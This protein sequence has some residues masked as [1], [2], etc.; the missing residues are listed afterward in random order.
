MDVTYSPSCG[1]CC[2]LSSVS[3]AAVAGIVGAQ[4][5]LPWL[6]PV[7][8]LLV[9][10]LI[11][12]TGWSIFWDSTH[13]LTDGFDEELE[14]ELEDRNI[15]A[16][17]GVLTD[18]ADYKA[19]RQQYFREL[20]RLQGPLQGLAGESRLNCFTAVT[21]HHTDFCGLQGPSGIHHVLEQ[22]P[23]CKGLQ[24]LRQTR[25]HTLALDGGEDD[26]ADIHREIRQEPGS[27]AG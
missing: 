20:F 1:P 19:A 25:A 6:D 7:A 15:D 26:D 2:C 5:Y 23:A 24:D 12:K 4:F 21:V 22:R 3:I 10:L 14:M 11:V 16:V 13:E 27:E 17:A 18:S 9:G 8:A